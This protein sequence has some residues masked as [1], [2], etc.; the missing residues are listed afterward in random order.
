MERKAGSTAV[1][2][3][4]QVATGLKSAELSSREEQALRMRYGVAVEKKSALPQ[5]H[6]GKESLAD[7]L[8]LIEMQL[9]RGLKA[10][11]GTKAKS[12]VKAKITARLSKK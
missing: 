6:G 5:A 11:Q 2:T 10:R 12:A 7:E 9:L 3:K 4:E 8:L 1:I